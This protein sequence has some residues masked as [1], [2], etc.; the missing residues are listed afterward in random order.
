MS[1]K[2][3][4]LDVIYDTPLKVI[5]VYLHCLYHT[6]LFTEIISDTVLNILKFFSNY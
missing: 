1:I 4:K 2:F 6:K 5:F 3:I